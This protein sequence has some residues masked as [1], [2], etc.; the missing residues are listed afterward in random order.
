VL[1]SSDSRTGLAAILAGVLIFAAQGGE[2]ALGSE[3]TVLNVLWVSLGAL[4]FAA[5]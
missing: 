3:P 4:G 5:L 1:L 2:L